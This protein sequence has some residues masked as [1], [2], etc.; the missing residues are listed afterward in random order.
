MEGQNIKV[1]EI[2]TAQRI[3]TK[4]ILQQLP[5]RWRNIFCKIDHHLFLWL[6]RY[7]VFGIYFSYKIFISILWEAD[8]GP[9]RYV[10]IL[11]PVNFTLFQKRVFADVIELRILKWGDY[12]GFIW[13]GPSC[14]HKCLYKREGRRQCDN[15]SREI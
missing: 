4:Q 13:L 2:Y 6:K 5:L 1:H 12:C 14:H 15:E 11:I 9:Q 3:I 10:H 7:P 8:N